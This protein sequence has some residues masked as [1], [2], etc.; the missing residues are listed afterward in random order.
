MFRLWSPFLRTTL[1]SVSFPERSIKQC[2]LTQNSVRH[3]K[4]LNKNISHLFYVKFDLVLTKVWC[5]FYVS[6]VHFC[7]PWRDV[8]HEDI[9]GTLCRTDF[10]SKPIISLSSRIFSSGSQVLCLRRKKNHESKKKQ[11]IN[12]TSSLC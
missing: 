5:F 2:L 1:F 9:A 4:L 10:C 12:C 8:Q 6:S 7:R 3:K 11:T